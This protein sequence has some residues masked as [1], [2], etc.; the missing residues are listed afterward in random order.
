MVST[1]TRRSSR[2]TDLP[3]FLPEGHA[4]GVVSEIIGAAAEEAFDAGAEF[5]DGDLAAFA[6]ALHVG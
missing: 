4:E 5:L 2:R 1:L 3:D 6:D